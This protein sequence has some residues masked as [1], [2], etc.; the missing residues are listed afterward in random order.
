[1]SKNLIPVFAMAT[2][3]SACAGGGQKTVEKSSPKFS[4]A[5]GEVKLMT[6][7]PPFPCCTGSKVD[8][9]TNRSNCLCLCS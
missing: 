3:L 6:L 4:G 2:L 5:K 1:M 8:V 7:D 9:R